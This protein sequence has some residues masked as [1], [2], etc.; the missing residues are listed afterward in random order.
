MT[1]ETSTSN[2]GRPNDLRRI[3]GISCVR[4]LII[5]EVVFQIIK[6][7]ISG[8]VLFL[9]RNDKIEE[10]LSAFLGGYIF[11]CAAKGLIFF[12]KN[13]V[14]FHINNFSEFEDSNTDISV[15]NNLI[16]GCNLFWYIIGF[17]WLQQCTNCKETSPLLFYTC[18][19]WL[20][21]GFLTFIGPLAAI[22]IL[23]ILVNYIKPTLKTIIFH[24]EEDL[25]DGNNRC[26]ICYE[27]YCDGCS[28][29]FLPCDHH[30]HT[31]CI[32]EWFNVRDS[33]PLCKKSINMLVDVIESNESIV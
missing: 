21:L 22:V 9:T 14:F 27:N 18:Y 29:K 2:Q 30:F 13:K 6:I 3:N 17:H 24:S 20:I 7:S 12:A 5:S 28:V 19:S 8:V 16:E 26:V 11:L 32:D 33:C 23:L 10:P 15:A 25:P 1:E 31:E 4:F